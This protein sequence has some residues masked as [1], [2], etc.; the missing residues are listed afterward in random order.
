MYERIIRFLTI[1]ILAIWVAALY[2]H[3]MAPN[4]GIE[5]VSRQVWPYA[6]PHVWNYTY[7]TTKYRTIECGDNPDCVPGD[8][9]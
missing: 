6:D 2:G 5:A 7:K 8:W 3:Y 1:A 4:G 9:R